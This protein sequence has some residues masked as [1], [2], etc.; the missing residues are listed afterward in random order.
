MKRNYVTGTA[1]SLMLAG[2]AM[3]GDLVPPSGSPQPTNRVQINQQTISSFP[4][5]ITQPGSYVFTSNITGVS[6]Q[7]GIAINADNVTI[8]MNGFS[9]IGV[10]GSLTAMQPGG[11]SNRH[12]LRVL[13]GKISDWGQFGIVFFEDDDCSVENVH[14]RNV[15]RD[16]FLMGDRAR[17]I[18]CSAILTGEDGFELGASAVVESSTADMNAE[19]GF[20][21]GSSSVVRGSVASNNGIDGFI[22]LGTSCL[23]TDSISFGNLGQGF[24]GPVGSTADHCVSR[25]N[26]G[27]GFRFSNGANITNCTSRFDVGHGI[28]VDVHSKVSNCTVT[29]PGM[30]GIT[31]GTVATIVNNTVRGAGTIGI[32]ADG[33]SIVDSCAV[34]S[35]V[36]EGVLLVGQECVVVNTASNNNGGD[37]IVS[38]PRSRISGCTASTNANGVKVG[39]SSVVQD[40]S[41]S[42]N[43]LAGIYG[44]FLSSGV[45]IGADAVLVEN[46]TVD[47]N[48]GNGIDLGD[49][50]VVRGSTANNNDGEGIFVRLGGV[51]AECSAVLNG[52]NGIRTFSGSTVSNS[53]TRQNGSSGIS[54]S[55]AGLVTNCAANNNSGIG[56]SGSAAATI[57][58]CRAYF[59]SGNGIQFGADSHIVG[60]HA[61]SNSGDANFRGA[62][63]DGSRVE[64]NTATDGVRGYYITGGGCFLVKNMART[65]TT[66]YDIA[67]GN[68]VGTLRGTPAGADGWDNMSF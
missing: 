17:V 4:Y 20:V 35:C 6:G 11:A 68:F 32:R 52:I 50:A 66:N 56:I 31:A 19:S 51:V 44:E 18:N 67:A 8:D 23:F 38:G 22:G 13:N 7:H 63:A 48:G 49:A 24:V 12:N 57:I 39:P 3:A 33:S 26:G 61:D 34:A 64:G 10:E 42:L 5:V 27:N 55:G 58:N 43:T 59:N 9:L 53:T 15:G 1:V 36:E 25:D 45:N 16:G 62:G 14:V 2:A 30:R 41:A 28:F 21:V 37:G 65:N 47:G 40:T 54:T 29:E 46:C 60:N